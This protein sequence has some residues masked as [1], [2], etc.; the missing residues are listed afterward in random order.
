MPNK[1]IF[2]IPI[3][4]ACLNAFSFTL[5]GLDKFKAKNK[6][7]RISEKSLIGVSFFGPV[8]A[9]LGMQYFR[10]KTEKP[11]FRFV[12]PFFLLLHVLFVLRTNLR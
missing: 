11:S 2:L 12:V 1:M 4:Y 8:G 3:I 9:L 7:W 10:H 5:Y 6:M